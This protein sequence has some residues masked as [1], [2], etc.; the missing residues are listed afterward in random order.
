MTV[1]LSVTLVLAVAIVA[2]RV[3]IAVVV[4]FALLDVLERLADNAPA[5]N[6]VVSS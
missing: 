2:G 6:H 3:L 5:P 4:R 1:L